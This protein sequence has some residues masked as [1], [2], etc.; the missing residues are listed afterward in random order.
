MARPGRIGYHARTVKKG[1]RTSCG[2]C[3]S[4]RVVPIVYGL[5]GG[6]LYTKAERGEVE[7]GGCVVFEDAPER[8]CRAC[9]ATWSRR[10]GWTAA[11]GVGEEPDDPGRA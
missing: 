1:E 11:E 10:H 5:P 2:I 4:D 6:E 9:G 8:R 3:G 7:L